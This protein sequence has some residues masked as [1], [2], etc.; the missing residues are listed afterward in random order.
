MEKLFVFVYIRYLVAKMSA[1]FSVLLC[2][3]FLSDSVHLHVASYFEI[4]F[5]YRE[6]SWVSLQVLECFFY[7]IFCISA[8]KTTFFIVELVLHK[9]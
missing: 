9:K 7:E 4:D 1:V 2:I 5:G 8:A 3:A 6:L